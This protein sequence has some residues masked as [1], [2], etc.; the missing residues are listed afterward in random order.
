MCAYFNSRIANIF[1]K[2]DCTDLSQA[3]L[4]ELGINHLLNEPFPY[5]RHCE[6]ITYS[7]ISQFSEQR[8]E[9]RKINLPR[10]MVY[11]VRIIFKIRIH[12][13]FFV[14]PIPLLLT[15]LLLDIV[16]KCRI[17]CFITCKRN[18]S[19]HCSSELPEKFI[20]ALLTTCSKQVF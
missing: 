17:K 18:F 1:H 11:E 16:S 7:L 20:S 10:I 15:I 3:P 14:F 2:S 6:R 13:Q 9:L 12:R 19:E 4:S 5:A 8:K